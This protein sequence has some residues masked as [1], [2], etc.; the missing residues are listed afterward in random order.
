MWFVRRN[1]YLLSAFQIFFL[2]YDR[3]WSNVV[4]AVGFILCRITP[5][6][7]FTTSL[8]ESLSPP[9]DLESLFGQDHY[10]WLCD[11]ILPL[12]ICFLFV[13][14]MSDD[15]A[16]LSPIFHL[17]QPSPIIFYPLFSK[18]R[19]KQGF[20]DMINVNGWWNLL[21]LVP[22]LSTTGWCWWWGICLW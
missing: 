4:Q 13:G 14:T 11:F 15:L 10:W 19:T 17:N 8:G 9:L 2:M 16:Y 12:F 7:S 21:V 18:W 3:W 5:E 6:N 20:G 22:W 1:G